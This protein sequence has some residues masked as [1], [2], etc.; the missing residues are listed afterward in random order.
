MA[1]CDVDGRVIKPLNDLQNSN[2]HFY[3]VLYITVCGFLKHSN[4]NNI[5]AFL[6]TLTPVSI[7][8]HTLNVHRK[9]ENNKQLDL[10]TH[11]GRRLATVYICKSKC[12]FDNGK[13]LLLH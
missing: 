3:K 11:N 8:Q 4:R 5:C 12:M 10:L 1:S 2:L 9:E 13:Y 6:I 7:C